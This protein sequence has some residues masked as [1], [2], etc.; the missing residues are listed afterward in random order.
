L[1]RRKLLIWRTGG[2]LFPACSCE[3]TFVGFLGF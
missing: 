1:E 2:P 3:R